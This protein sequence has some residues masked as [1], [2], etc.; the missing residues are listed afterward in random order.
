MGFYLRKSISV[1]PLRFNLS[2]S[3]VGVSAGVKGFRA[4]T[5]PRGNYVHMGRHGV[6]YRATLPSGSRSAGT[7]PTTPT[8]PP[9]APTETLTQ[10]QSGNVERMVDA[11]SAELIAEL[12]TKQKRWRTA[13]W[14]FFAFFVLFAM[15]GYVVGGNDPSQ[16]NLAL[17]I[18]TLVL[19]AAWVALTWATYR[20]DVMM[21][22]TVL[23]FTVED[24]ASDRFQAVHTAFGD[25]MKSGGCWQVRAQGQTSDWKH[26]AGASHL[27]R[28]TSVTLKTDPPRWVKTNIGVPTIPLARE[29]LCFFPD[30]LLVFALD[31]VGAVSYTGLNITVSARR[32]IEGDSV[33][34]DAKSSGRHGSIRT[35]PAA[36]TSGSKTTA[37]FRLRC[38][39]K[40]SSRA[41]PA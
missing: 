1:G 34:K 20:H 30:R 33:P 15:W 31:G 27:I 39:S 25:L 23:L 24:E 9:S 7:A 21:K 2:K 40:S 13:P 28:R 29:T 4:G 35:R 18:V 11:T 37:N 3:G 32:F 19:V 26:E 41:C 10:I 12:N 22:T 38:T 17:T 5:G 8:L 14:V 6:Y 36:R 16:P